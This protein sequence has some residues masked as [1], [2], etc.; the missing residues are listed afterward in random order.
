MSGGD[1]GV[2]I[3]SDGWTNVRNQHLINILG[4]SATDAVFL[5]AHDSSIIASSQNIAELLLKTINDVGPSNVIQVI[6]DNA[7]NCKGAR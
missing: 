4:V 2:S 3:V 6:T 7:T 1:F 5:A